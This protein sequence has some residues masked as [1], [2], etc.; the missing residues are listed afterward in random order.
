M[1]KS[2]RASDLIHPLIFYMMEKTCLFANEADAIGG[3]RSSRQFWREERRLVPH[4]AHSGEN[5]ATQL[6]T[7]RTDLALAP[8]LS[9]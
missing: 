7:R 8:H 9:H 1:E 5:H 4:P 3:G 6:P 2:A